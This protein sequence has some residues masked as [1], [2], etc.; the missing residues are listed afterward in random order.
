MSTRAE[1]EAEF[2]DRRYGA[3][4]RAK[5]DAFYTDL[6]SG[7]YYRS[8]LEQSPAGADVLEYGC[9]QGSALLALAN[10]RTVAAIDISPVAIEQ[11]RP[12]AE[13]LDLTIDF[14][15]ANAES[16]PFADDSFDLECGSGIL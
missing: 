13:E 14:Q 4:T 12:R 9:G 2:H 8:L 5:L 16:L 6:P 10:S 7:A 11:A 15:V 1:R 3:N